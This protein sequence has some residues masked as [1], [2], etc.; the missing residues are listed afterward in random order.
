MR[1]RVLFGLLLLLSAVSLRG[2]AES[3][4][5]GIRFERT[6]TDASSVKVRVFDAEGRAIEGLTTS[7]TCS[8]SL[9]SAGAAV[10]PAIVCPDVNG[11]ISPSINLTIT[12][13][14]LPGSFTY[15]E[16]GLD[17]HALNGSGAYQSND[18]GK[19]RQY[20]VAVG[21]GDDGGPVSDFATLGNIDIA[22]G[23]GQNGSVH[24]YWALTSQTD[25]TVSG[26]LVLS[27]TVTKGN[28]NQGCFF[29][30]SGITVGGTDEIAE[31]DPSGPVDETVPKA[32]AVYYIKWFSDASQYMTETAGGALVVGGEDKTERQFWEFVPTGRANCFHIRNTATGHY[33]QSCN[34]EASSASKVNAGVTPVEYYVVR[35]ETTGAAVRGY[36]RMTSTDC[37]NYDNTA[38]TPLGLNKDGASTSII[39]WHAGNS[40]NGSYWMLAET[41][42]RYELRPFTPS[43][44]IGTPAY[45]YALSRADGRVLEMGDDG[46]LAWNVQTY[47]SR[48]AWY[49]V[50]KSNHVDGYYI[51][52]AA[53]HRLLSAAGEDGTRWCVM[54]DADAGT[55]FFFRPFDRRDDAGTALAVDGDSLMQVRLLRSDFARSARIYNQPC[56]LRGANYLE[57]ASVAGDGVLAPLDYPLPVLA[58]GQVTH[59]AAPAPSTWHTVYTQSKAT[60][61]AGRSFDLAF[62]LNAAPS[63]DGQAW[64][65]FDWDRDGIFETAR[66]LTM[67]QDIRT[68]VD[69]PA[70]LAQEG[71]TRMRFRLTANGLSDA[72]DDVDGQ[73]VDFILNVVTA[74]PGIYPA[75]VRSNDPERGT[76]ALLDSADGL[77]HV[78]EATPKGNASFLCWKEGERV[79][80]A[81]RVYDFVRDHAIDLV[82]CFSPNTQVETGVN[83]GLTDEAGC[84]VEITNNDGL[85]LVV[86][87]TPVRRIKVYSA[88]GALVARA[89]GARVNVQGLPAGTY[90]VKVETAGKGASV[91]VSLK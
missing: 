41:D 64:V 47:D 83:E 71:S 89:D 6:G 32:G 70:G 59:P 62:R 74:M 4:K 50:G 31:A 5:I 91:K 48:Q 57:S 75:S 45:K 56:G 86:S 87:D 63:D 22:S 60:V 35:N 65:Y 3:G 10:T 79:V 37:N 66:E 77:P 78:A 58:G 16:M 46:R 72:E 52:N 13:D 1:K 76:A 38:A 88:A 20:D 11:N 53:G 49:F 81:D 90:I 84:V 54:N 21:C 7:L 67:G 51:V 14:G 33:I 9:K 36:F 30:L 69:V 19:A 28:D 44:A 18:D 80:S 15:N 27:I 42:D 39:A 17:I 25:R 73:V 85:L 82:A 23:V 2:A 26:K 29:A 24:K 43:E 12:I 40:N 61:V 8:H 68:K 34:L 55:S